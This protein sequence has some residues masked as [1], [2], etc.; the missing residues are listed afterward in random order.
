M[1]TALYLHNITAPAEELNVF[2][3]TLKKIGTVEDDL[4]FSLEE[5]THWYTDVCKGI[6]G[7]N[8]T[9]SYKLFKQKGWDERTKEQ[10]GPAIYF[11]E[12]VPKEEDYKLVDSDKL[13]TEVSMR[14]KRL[15]SHQKIFGMFCDKNTDR[16][17][18]EKEI[19][20]LTVK[21]YADL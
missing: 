19:N 15:Y 7:N 8:H 10:V 3:N 20:D 1:N 14:L 12:Q 4:R 18:L 6:F 5:Q 13:L 11:D 2:R 16:D 21:D 17:V 9:T